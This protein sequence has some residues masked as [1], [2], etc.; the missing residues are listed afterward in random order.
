MPIFSTAV[1]ESAS[2]PPTVSYR[3]AGGQQNAFILLIPTDVE[4]TFGAAQQIGNIAQF[5]VIVAVLRAVYNVIA[6]RRYGF[7]VDL[8]VMRRSLDLQTGLVA[9][10]A[11]RRDRSECS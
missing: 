10:A 2:S 8:D 4:L 3:R 6:L 1:D 5:E 7:A 11:D 9:R